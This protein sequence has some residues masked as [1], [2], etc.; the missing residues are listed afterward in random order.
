LE[1]NSN[2]SARAKNEISITEG[3]SGP[4]VLTHALLRM[5]Q[6]ADNKCDFKHFE[7]FE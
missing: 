3:N 5:Q 7:G 2:D 1:E 4:V 6:L